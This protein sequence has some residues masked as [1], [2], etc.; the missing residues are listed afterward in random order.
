MSEMYFLSSL[1]QVPNMVSVC[2]C[3]CVLSRYHEGWIMDR[4]FLTFLFDNM[5]VVVI[6][7]LVMKTVVFLSTAVVFLLHRLLFCMAL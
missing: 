6:G 3:V 7:L 1:I 5:P 2:V 4:S